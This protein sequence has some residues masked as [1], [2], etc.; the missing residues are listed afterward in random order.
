MCIEKSYILLILLDWLQVERGVGRKITTTRNETRCRSRNTSFRY[1][2][3]A[4]LWAMATGQQ[5]R[6]AARSI[7]PGRV[8]LLSLRSS[9]THPGAPAGTMGR[10]TLARFIRLHPLATKTESRRPA[11]CAAE[12]STA[13][14]PHTRARVARRGV[15]SAQWTHTS[16]GGRQAK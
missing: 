11:A 14:P 15:R 10:V 16:V 13:A 9:A 7:E 12:D 1:M 4:I 5:I 6:K 2:L 8:S 3:C